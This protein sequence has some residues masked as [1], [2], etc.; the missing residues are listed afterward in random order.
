MLVQERLAASCVDFSSN[1]VT[2]A[3]SFLHDVFIFSME[4]ISVGKVPIKAN[5]LTKTP[6]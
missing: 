4:I 5:I 2:C 3:G 6:F 1:E